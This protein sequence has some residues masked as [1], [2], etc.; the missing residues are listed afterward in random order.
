MALN[1]RNNYDKI[2]RKVQITSCL[3][4]CHRED[5]LETVVDLPGVWRRSTPFEN[6]TNWPLV[7]KLMDRWKTSRMDIENK[8][9]DRNRWLVD[10]TVPLCTTHLMNF[11]WLT[12]AVL[13]TIRMIKC[14]FQ[15]EYAVLRR[16]TM[17]G[18][19]ICR[20]WPTDH[21]GFLFGTSL[22]TDVKVHGVESECPQ[23]IICFKSYFHY[24]NWSEIILFTMISIQVYR[25][26]TGQ[27]RI[28]SGIL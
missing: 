8:L 3:V 24:L 11:E 16:V 12:N 19:K 10:L 9:K 17:L 22:Y 13:F 21:V 26:T 14:M 4:D 1:E 27:R 20:T 7:R 28:F 2:M 23:E 15:L 18:L 6:L 25:P 5:R